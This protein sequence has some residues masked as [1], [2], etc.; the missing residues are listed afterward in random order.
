MKITRHV[1]PVLFNIFEGFNVD[2]FARANPRGLFIV[3]NGEKPAHY[4]DNG[5]IYHP[6]LYALLIKPP[7]ARKERVKNETL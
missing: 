4:I 1:C 5:S 3:F 6:Q 2:K 7:K